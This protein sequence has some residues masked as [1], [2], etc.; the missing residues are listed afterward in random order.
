MYKFQTTLV[1][2]VGD[3]ENLSLMKHANVFLSY[4]QTSVWSS[5][6]VLR[7]ERKVID[8]TPSMDIYSFAMVMWEIY[9]QAMPF[10]GD[11]SIAKKFVLE[12]DSRPKIAEEVDHD[13]A[14][15]IRVCW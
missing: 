4:R 1:V 8:P 14:K 15:I 10:D 12:E 9:H 6:E 2:K 13:I 11:I 5:P 7:Q 3:F